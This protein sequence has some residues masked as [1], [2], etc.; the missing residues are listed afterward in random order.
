MTSVAIDQLAEYALA[1]AG[2]GW[3]IVPVHS[4]DRRGRCSC[5]KDTCGHPGK[6]P[7]T[8][9]GLSDA[10]ADP[11]IIREWWKQ[12]PDANIGVACRKSGFVAIDVD[13][14][15]GG[16]ERLHELEDE[17]G[18]LPMTIQARTGGG[19]AHLLFT[20]PGGQIKGD[21][22][23]GVDLRSSAYTVVDPSVHA[24]GSRYEWLPDQGPGDI[25]PASLPE[26]WVQQVHRQKTGRR[27]SGAGVTARFPE[28]TRNDGL[29]S[30]AGSL[31]RQGLSG[32]EIAE[33]LIPLN[34]QH[35]D[36]PL[37]QADVETLAFGM[38]RYPPAKSSFPL[39]DLGNAERVVARHGHELRC[40]ANCWH[41]YDGQ[42]WVPDTTSEA[43]R[44]VCETVR[45]MRSE[46]AELE[47]SEA[48]K[49]VNWALKS[50]AKV[51]IDAANALAKTMAPVV[52]TFDQF[53]ADPM[54]LNVENGTLDLR[55]GE[56]REYH[57]EDYITKL[58]PVCFDLGATC[59]GWNAF[60][61]RILAGNQNLIAYVQTAVGYSLTGLT[62]EQCFFTHFG[63]GANGKTTFAEVIRSQMGD[64]AVQADATLI[65]RRSADAVRND[66]A[67][68]QGARMVQIM[69][70]EEGTKLD[71]RLVKNITGGDRLAARYLYKEHFEFN[72]ECKLWIGTNHKPELGDSEAI[73]RRVRRIPFEVFIPEAERDPDLVSKLKTELPGILNWALEGCLRYQAEGLG[74]PEEVSRAVAEY[75]MEEDQIG[76][77][78]AH[79]CF[80]D[81]TYGASSNH[82]HRAYMAWCKDEGEVALEKVHFGRKL[83]ERPG[84]LSHRRS[85]GQG[86]KGIE[87]DFERG[88]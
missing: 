35:C 9:N 6:H 52:M 55:T 65:M 80:L 83:G 70:L 68:L 57:R 63:S 73:W 15:H 60:L 69:E 48:S 50:E 1:Y 87:V 17:F 85:D 49:L 39:T 44:L 43:D 72:A 88:L 58:A 34:E 16:A 74:A 25:E 31:R 20:D 23:L 67:R 13:P 84:L 33:L 77:F 53:D 45:S 11:E 22:G 46:A 81:K 61:D 3:H 32:D 12:W 18:P 54:L 38:E 41:V 26:A 66:L 64:Y 24:S 27:R 47:E 56:L 19:G 28:G 42:R 29:T 21:L 10:T 30:V 86:W 51:K 8:K 82:L 5:R 4:V 14:R 59:P 2:L 76:R 79:R 40:V 36:P 7:R 78:I 37:D 62:G 71:E 75:R